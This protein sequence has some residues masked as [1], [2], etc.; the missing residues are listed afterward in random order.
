MKDYFHNYWYAEN[1]FTEAEALEL[2]PRVNEMYRVGK[3]NSKWRS[4]TMV[5]DLN[6]KNGFMVVIEKGT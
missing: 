1:G 4:A 3:Y 2:I 5:S 6:K